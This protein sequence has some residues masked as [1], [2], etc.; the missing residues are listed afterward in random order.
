M[1]DAYDPPYQL[2]IK[3]HSMTMTITDNFLFR[4]LCSLIA[5]LT[6]C[7]TSLEVWL[8]NRGKFCASELPPQKSQLGKFF[9]INKIIQRNLIKNFLTY[10][11]CSFFIRHLFI[12]YDSN[13]LYT[14]LGKL[15]EAYRL[16][17]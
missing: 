10:L 3:C 2:F 1:I 9:Y 5:V 15:L 6:I 7:G 17:C 13:F 11:E 16:K 4:F 12:I 14:D 8:I